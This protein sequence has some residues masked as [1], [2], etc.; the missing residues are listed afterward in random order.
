MGGVLLLG[1]FLLV[2][3]LAKSK[4]AKR[5][6]LHKDTISRHFSDVNQAHCQIGAHCL[7]V[8]LKMKCGKNV[9]RA[10]EPAGV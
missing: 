8:Q 7:S 2:R 9:A 1:L 10:I 4:S 3:Q 5:F 6:D